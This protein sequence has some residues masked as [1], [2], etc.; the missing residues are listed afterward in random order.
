[1]QDN[2]I[3]ITDATD[4]GQVIMAITE[5][6][7]V[8][9]HPFLRWNVAAPSNGAWAGCL[10]NFRNLVFR[11]DADFGDGFISVSF[12]DRSECT[13]IRASDKHA[14]GINRTTGGRPFD[15]CD[16]D[17]LSVLVEP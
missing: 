8:E 16:H 2:P 7:R 14:F 11:C 5:N 13:S 1:M 6:L 10:N 4:C 17:G 3:V 12:S 15:F 9:L